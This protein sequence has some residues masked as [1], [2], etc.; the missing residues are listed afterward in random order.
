MLQAGK[1]RDR[2]EIRGEAVTSQNS[3]G[4]DVISVVNVGTFWGR[5]SIL[6]G[7]ELVA[8]QQRFAKASYQIELRHQP[9][10]TF[11]PKM[12]AIW[13]NRVLDILDVQD[14]GLRSPTIKMTAQDYAG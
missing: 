5:V 9:G 14:E 11:S 4:E 1:L 7:T 13:N 2:V 8:A 6:Q 12:S 10:I 3:F